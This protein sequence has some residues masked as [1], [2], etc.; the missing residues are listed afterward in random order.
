MAGNP[1]VTTKLMTLEVFANKA[2]KKFEF[3]CTDKSIEDMGWI[4]KTWDFKADADE[5]VLEIA[6]AMKT[7][8]FA[9][10]ALDDVS[11]KLLK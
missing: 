8:A 1:G 11:V 9:G 4:K 5:T 6:T 2:S 3:D 7:E 10:P